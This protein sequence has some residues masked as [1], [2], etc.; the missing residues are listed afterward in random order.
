MTKSETV[1][2]CKQRGSRYESIPKP[3]NYQNYPIL[4]SKHWIYGPRKIKIQELTFDWHRLCFSWSLTRAASGSNDELCCARSFQS[5][6]LIHSGRKREPLRPARPPPPLCRI[7][8]GQLLWKL[9]LPKQMKFSKHLRTPLPQHL[10]SS[11]PSDSENNTPE[12]KWCWSQS[13]I[14]VSVSISYWSLF[15]FFP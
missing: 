2:L 11:H 12:I 1:S 15:F 8:K 4:F 13:H 7:S 3:N 14:Y 9:G 5:T 6:S 10:L